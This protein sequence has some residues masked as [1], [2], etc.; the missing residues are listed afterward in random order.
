MR[1]QLFYY[2]ILLCFLA[3]LINGNILKAQ[4]TGPVAPEAA[5]FEPVEANNMV[6]LNTG[7]FTY[8][9]PIIDIPGPGGGYPLTLSYHGGIKLEQESSWVGLGWNINPG[10]ITRNLRGFPDDWKGKRA[11]VITYVG[12]STEEDFTIDLSV[13]KAGVGISVSFSSYASVGV[14]VNFGFENYFSASMGTNGIGVGFQLSGMF[15]AGSPTSAPSSWKTLSSFGNIGLRYSFNSKQISSNVGIGEKGFSLGVSMN[16]EG[17][18]GYLSTPLGGSSFGVGNSNAGINTTISTS[19]F[20][21]PIWTK[22]GNLTLTYNKYK[23]N[24]FSK[25]G[26]TVYGPLYYNEA[27]D[28]D[29][30][31][32]QDRGKTMDLYANPF[33][34]STYSDSEKD[35]RSNRFKYP[36]YDGYVVVAQGIGGVMRPRLFEFGGLT[37]GHL[38]F[39]YKYSGNSKIPSELIYRDSYSKDV[40]TNNTHNQIHFY[41]EG[42]NGGFRRISEAD[43]NI[44][45]AGI[46][47]KDISFRKKSIN[48]VHVDGQSQ[49]NEMN[50]RHAQGK[51]VEWFSNQ[52]IRSGV[53]NDFGFIQEDDIAKYRNESTEIEF[54]KNFDPDGIGGYLITDVDGVTYHYSIPVYQHEQITVQE[55]KT[56]PKE[57][58]KQERRTG[59]YATTWLLTA[60]T[61]PDF[62]DVNQDNRLGDEDIG[63]WVKFKYG[64]WSNGYIWR[65]P[66]E[67][68]FDD[69]NISDWGTY[70]FGRKEIYYLN[71]VET[72]THIA[73]FIKSKRKDGLS[74][75]SV[76]ED[77]ENSRTG[78]AKIGHKILGEEIEGV[79]SGVY[80]ASADHSLNYNFQSEH[81]VLK[82]DKIVLYKKDKNKPFW[83][84][85]SLSEGMTGNYKQ[86]N[87]DVTNLYNMLGQSLPTNLT[88]NIE[89]KYSDK[90]DLQFGDS[91]SSQVLEDTET[92]GDYTSKDIVKSIDLNYDYSLAKESNNSN[93]T[94]KGRLTLT[95]VIFK[96]TESTLYMPPYEFEYINNL[97]YDGD[98]V[99]DWGYHKEQAEL[100]SLNEIKTPLGAKINISYESDKFHS[101]A[102]YPKDMKFPISKIAASVIYFENNFDAK[103]YFKKGQWIALRCYHYWYGS[104]PVGQHGFESFVVR[105][106]EVKK[107]VEIEELFDHSFKITNGGWAMSDVENFV[108]Y[109]VPPNVYGEKGGGVRVSEIKLVDENLNEYSTAYKYT[110]NTTGITSGITSYSPSNLDIKYVPYIYEIPAPGVMYKKVSVIQSSNKAAPTKTCFEFDVLENAQSIIGL[111][112]N[113]G[114]KLL[115]E[116]QQTETNSFG[117]YRND[118]R[119]VVVHDKTSS[120][121]ALKSK[122]SYSSQGLMVSKSE[123]ISVV[124]ENET[125]GKFQESFHSMSKIW[126]GEQSEALCDFIVAS[127]I[128]YPS[129][130]VAESQSDGRR[131]IVTSYDDVDFITGK[132]NLI[133]SNIDDVSISSVKKISAYSKYPKMGSKALNIDNKNMLSQETAS[134]Q[135]KLIGDVEKLIGAGVQTW[136][137]NWVYREQISSGSYSD[138]SVNGIWRN[139]KSFAWKGNL[140]TDGT[141]SGFT[142]YAWGN[143]DTYNEGKGWQKTSEV[144]RYSAF[145]APLEEKDINGNH[146]ATRYNASGLNLIASIGNARWEEFTFSSFENV[147]AVGNNWCVEGELQIQKASTTP[148]I[149]VSVPK[150]ERDGFAATS[151]IDSHA[152]KHYLKC[153]GEVQILCL[154]EMLVQAPRSYR[155]SCWVHKNSSASTQFKFGYSPDGTYSIMWKTG[156]RKRRFGNWDLM[157]LDVTLPVEHERFDALYV[158]VSSSGVAY[159]DDF[160]IHPIDAPMSAYV[161]DN[162]TD[163]L[164][165]ILDRE[166]IATKYYYDAGGRLTKVEKETQSGF[167]IVSENSY[168]YATMDDTSIRLS[169]TRMR[170]E[171]DHD[172]NQTFTITCE[173]NWTITENAPISVSKSS[174]KGNATITVIYTADYTPVY[175]DGYITVSSATD[176]KKVHVEIVGA[177][178]Q[179][180]GP[181]NP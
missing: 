142:N 72:K 8:V 25:Q 121:G 15:K 57:E 108:S 133:K 71:T 154:D 143:S 119:S 35:I 14:N 165:A 126:D 74:V 147:K 51:Y 181:L 117:K 164:T 78:V 85:E 178:P 32:K 53:S 94:T 58:F 99:D 161:Y 103:K 62:V 80:I 48:S 176:E 5:S 19:T 60:I 40:F 83:K 150:D 166:N 11:D 140:D 146:G 22:F 168:K 92:L 162:K 153:T 132:P 34:A 9:L 120:L 45:N 90:L 97:N 68:Y 156:G 137:D 28:L 141:Y 167:N 6:Q 124:P 174:G 177:R 42:E 49:Y 75:S 44:V 93:A 37:E 151:G 21:L 69:D 179:P 127:K 46:P 106:S 172:L 30:S 112:Y 116:N 82:L 26:K 148:M 105:E 86:N 39:K 29:D 159:V 65:T 20:C 52:E 79:A 114:D 43:Y 160:R 88:A 180:D 24:F 50:K 152:G 76:F 81:K 157:T 18:A 125:T 7:D 56:N 171:S 89:K 113:L 138:K 144:T 4:N 91:F 170:F 13:R 134:Y 145:S 136:K 2:S 77:G 163:A 55:R 84:K 70:S 47:V 36:N 139:H 102:V 3:I 158:K 67:G 33:D 101:Q 129:F 109:D 1:N 61:G 64:K 87:Y 100:W 111:N 122:T 173:G 31:G 59:K 175:N 10:T 73:A 38:N 149:S 104:R 130:L 27:T 107:F 131:K 41:F 63:Y 12:G 135:Y 110:D 95:S 115:I 16:K 96:G 66:Y 118:Y 169:E 23:I 123:Y 54:E 98:K 128:T 17:G 155:V